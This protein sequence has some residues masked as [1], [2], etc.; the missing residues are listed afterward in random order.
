MQI[1]ERLVGDVAILTI[2]GDLD[3]HT[4]PDATERLDAHLKILRCRL[5]FNLSKLDI[6]TSTAIG[7]LVDAARRTRKL[8]GDTVVSEP[9]RLFQKT[10]DMLHAG[11]VFKTFPSDNEAVGYL[12]MSE[13]G[14]GS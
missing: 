10:M 2:S 12:L 11:E 1:D 6:V 9:T 8:G 5:V 13:Q 14:D 7:F 4:I 3:A